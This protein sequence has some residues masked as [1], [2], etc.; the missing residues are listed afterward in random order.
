[1]ERRSLCACGEPKPV[2]NI[3]FMDCNM[4]IMDGFEA[5]KEIRKL[6]FIDQDRMGIIALTANTND[7]YKIRGRECG[8][9]DFL[10]KP[11]SAQSIKDV[12][13]KYRILN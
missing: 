9:N 11:V 6:D 2:Y 5:T 3:I 7:S 8:M 10:S 4:P 13:T 1:M 12:L